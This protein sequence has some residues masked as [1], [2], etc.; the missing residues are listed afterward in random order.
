VTDA[1]IGQAVLDHLRERWRT[2]D[3]VYCGQGPQ[4]VK[5]PIPYT[6]ADG[7]TALFVPVV[8][9]HCSSTA[10]IDAHDVERL[11]PLFSALAAQRSHQPPPG[12]VH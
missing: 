7:V 8:C 12:L 10:L 6:D 11:E 2:M 9:G 5:M 1:E 3:C 4:L